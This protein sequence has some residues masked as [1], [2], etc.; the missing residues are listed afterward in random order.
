MKSI[1][2]DLL[3]KGE[4]G[5]FNIDMFH[6]FVKSHPGFLFPAFQIQHMLQSKIIGTHYWSTAS[7]KRIKLSNGQYLR[8]SEL[9]K[10]VNTCIIIIISHNFS[11]VTIDSHRM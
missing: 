3:D 2:A 1:A 10:M 11:L 5:K 4:S 9:L 6:A 7:D 8:F